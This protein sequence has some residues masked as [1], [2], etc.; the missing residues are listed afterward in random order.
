MKIILF[1]PTTLYCVINAC[2]LIGID[3]LN[4]FV[5]STP[6][7]PKLRGFQIQ[8]WLN[9]VKTKYNQVSFLFKQ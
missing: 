6:G 9:I 8:E 4:T 2:Q 3:V 5:G 7:V 1:S